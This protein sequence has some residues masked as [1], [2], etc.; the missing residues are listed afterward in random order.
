MIYA[1]EH[2]AMA[3]ALR[4]THAR[5]LAE[6]EL[7]WRRDLVE[8][9]IAGVEDDSVFA[10]SDAV[11]HNLHGPHYARVVQWL[12]AG[13]EE[14]IA[15]AAQ[16]AAKKIGMSSLL[17]RRSGAV[18]LFGSGRPSGDGFCRAVSEEM[19][20]DR[21]AIGIGGCC[22]HPEEC[23]RSFREALRALRFLG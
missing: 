5:N 1:L 8:D 7:R 16:Q 22:E 6:I 12:D 21:G 14:A 17:M 20:T 10:R 19:G 3:L 11:G 13:F 9:L 18:V 4:L 2:G 23:V 15:F